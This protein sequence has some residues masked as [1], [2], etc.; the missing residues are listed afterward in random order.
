LKKRSHFAIKF[1][2]AVMR[3]VALLIVI[4]GVIGG[5]AFTQFQNATISGLPGAAAALGYLIAVVFTFNNAIIQWGFADALVLIADTN[6]AQR[7]TQAQVAQLMAER[8]E[9][10][11]SMMAPV[12]SDA[13]E[14]LPPTNR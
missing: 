7:V 1:T 9:P 11:V 10:R 5:L 4:G 14:R 6:D 8:G 13:S 2:A 12:T 3:I